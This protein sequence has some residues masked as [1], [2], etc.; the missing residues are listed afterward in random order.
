MDSCFSFGAESRFSALSDLE[1]KLP[2]EDNASLDGVAPS[3]GREGGVFTDP[4]DPP[5]F[6]GTVPELERMY[7]SEDLYEVVEGLGET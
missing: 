1:S 3:E 7:D 6:A 4:T 5:R 2:F